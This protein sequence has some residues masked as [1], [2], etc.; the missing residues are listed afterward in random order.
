MLFVSFKGTVLD[1]V[2][3]NLTF[4]TNSFNKGLDG[5]A[6]NTG[7]SVYLSQSKIDGIYNYG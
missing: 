6:M 3:K 7:R 5:R 4:S 1:L 2:I